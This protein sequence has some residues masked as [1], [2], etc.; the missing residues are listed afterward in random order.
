M[1]A[2]ASRT[3][4]PATAPP[5]LSTAR[6]RRGWEPSSSP[7]PRWWPTRRPPAASG[8]SCTNKHQLKCPH[9]SVQTAATCGGVTSLDGDTDHCIITAVTPSQPFQALLQLYKDTDKSWSTLTFFPSHAVSVSFRGISKYQI[10]NYLKIVR[11]YRTLHSS[12]ARMTGLGW[13]ALAG[14]GSIPQLSA[15]LVLVNGRHAS[16]HTAWH[17]SV[18]LQKYLQKVTKY[19]VK[20]SCVSPLTSRL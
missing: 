13:A 8:M 16:P 1:Q 3:R 4:P 5:P 18:M 7:W 2:R 20:L 10:S 11:S 6:P 14:L 9:H 15:A 19:F 17:I 12:V